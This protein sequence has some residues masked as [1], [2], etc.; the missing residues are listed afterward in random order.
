MNV[1]RIYLDK[2]SFYWRVKA[3]V[4]DKNIV[5]DFL[6]FEFDYNDKLKLIIQK[7][8]KMTLRYLDKVYRQVPNIGNI[9]E[10]NQWSNL[11]G[12]DFLTFINSS[13][14]KTGKKNAKILEIG[15]G[16]CL[17]L[18]NLKRDG[19]EVLGIDPSPFARE[20]G[21]KRGV[22][23]IQDSFPSK[24]LKRKF[25]LIFHSD[26]LEHV[27]DPVEFLKTQF[28]HLDDDGILIISIPDCTDS[29]AFGDISMILHQH[30]NYFDRESLEI[31]VKMAGF[32]NVYIQEANYGG[33]LYCFA[34]KKNRT[35]KK[36]PIYTNERNIKFKN[37]L[38][39]HI[40]LKSRMKLYLDRVLSN[41]KTSLGF[42]APVR[43]FPYLSLMNLNAGFR[44]FDDTAYWHMKY[45]D[46]FPAK[47]ENFDD[48]KNDPVTDLLIMSPTFGEKIRQ[49]IITG[50]HSK[51]RVKKITDFFLNSRY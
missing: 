21:K 32:E 35:K 5:P 15:C 44:F 34:R 29:L 31:V 8:N 50:F 36:S 28:E 43:S 24:K 38:R 39:K 41:K 33:S 40:K 14:S 49:K 11:Y 7:R 4:D 6:P 20:E 16:G 23:V 1:N 25:D 22:T 3:D 13:I 26:V 2:L 48:L 18:E 9:Q 27:V 46:G 42:Y 12:K 47:I 19:H 51:I 10:V 17:L 37:F 45:F 30:L